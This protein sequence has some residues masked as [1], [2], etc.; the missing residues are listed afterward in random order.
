MNINSTITLIVTLFVT[1]ANAGTLIFEKSGFSINALDSSPPLS[2]AQPLQMSLPAVNGF[3]ANISVQIQPYM[4]TLSQYKALSDSQFKQNGFKSILSKI[5]NNYVL[6]EFTGLI[7]GKSFHW[8]SKAYKKG[9]F[10]YLV[11]ATEQEEN[12]KDTK[13]DLI[14]AVE[15]FKLQ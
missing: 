7:T 8:Y 9:D 14:T 2:G 12:W 10:V 5:N 11:T 1:S 6:Y 13:N 4:G 3:S 15:S